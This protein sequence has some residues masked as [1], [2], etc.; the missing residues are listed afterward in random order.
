MKTTTNFMLGMH[1]WV[2]TLFN[3]TDLLGNTNKCDKLIL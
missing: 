2:P 1:K 3:F